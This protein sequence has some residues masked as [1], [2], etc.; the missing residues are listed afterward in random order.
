MTAKAM[1]SPRAAAIEASAEPAERYWNA[2]VARDRAFDGLFVFSV[3][4]TGV[5][6]R[7]SCPARRAKRENVAFHETWQAAEAAGFRA[8][9]RCRPREASQHETDTARV[10]AACRRIEEAEEVPSLTE[11][12]AEAALSPFHF[13]RVFKAITGVTPKA[14]GE[15]H[16]RGRVREGLSRSG[17][18][19]EAIHDAGFNSSGRFYAGAPDALGMTP[20]AFRNGGCGEEI[21][22]A[23]AQCSLGAVLVAASGK[24]IAAILLGDDPE[25][26]VHD[27][28]DRFPKAA[29]V[30]GDA[31]FERVVAQV[32]GLIEA[33][34]AA[35]DLPLDIRGTAFQQRVWAALRKIRPGTTATYTEIAQRIGMP[36]AVRAVAA[37]CGANP[38]AIAVPC[39][40]VVRSDGSL[41]GY[42]W[43][44][45]RKE[46]LL[47][48]E[49]TPRVKA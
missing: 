21:R 29:L 35:F 4:T 44:I 36:K 32:I 37:A 13:H 47:A 33:P 17:T 14:Y 20:G 3:A 30:G 31:A 22:F 15:A 10:A 7:P 23:V 43:G 8:C 42:R 27:L 1:A 9:R 2:V 19:T 39:H 49:A 11:L 6:C 24:G 18:V 40:R 12:A 5:Y 46:R 28:E 34:A 41:A 45:A 48:R 16:R 26:L 25:A 38:I